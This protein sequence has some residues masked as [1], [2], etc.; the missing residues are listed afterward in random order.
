MDLYA[1]LQMSE[2]LKVTK[3]FALVLLLIF[4]TVLYCVILSH[5]GSHSYNMCLGVGLLYGCVPYILFVYMQVVSAQ[6]SV[7]CIV[8][9]LFLYSCY[10]ISILCLHMFIILNLH[11]RFGVTMVVQ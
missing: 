7:I 10:I 9:Y 2:N 4:I 8:W 6:N 3:L 1:C 5:N 11:Y